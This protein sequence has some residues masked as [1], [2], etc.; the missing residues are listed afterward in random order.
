MNNEIAIFCNSFTGAIG[1]DR[2]V[3][4]QAKKLSLISGNHVTIITF[5]K[6]RLPPDGVDIIVIKS[7]C[8]FVIER[9]WRLFFPFN[10]ITISYLLKRIKNIDTIYSHQYPLNWLAYLGKEFYGIKY[11]Y[12]HHHLN[13]PESYI[14][15]IQQIYAKLLNILTLWTAKKSNCAISIS[16]YSRKSLLKEIGLDSIV[17]YNEIDKDRFH[18]GIDGTIIR[19]RYNIDNEPIIL[20]VGGITP[21]KGIHLLINV[22]QIVKNRFPNAKLII[23]GKK[24]FDKYY[25]KLMQMNDV[26]II[27]TG[28]I[29]DDELPLYYASCNVYATASLWE[30]FN[31]P[32][33]EAK[34]CGKPIV[35]FD[36]G[37]HRELIDSPETGL[38][39]P[40]S[41]IVVM[42]EA[43]IEILSFQKL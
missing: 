10:I 33:V 9:L 28:Y 32:L 14:G 38:L 29:S 23:V 4:S 26:S 34:S 15:Q 5:K 13:P 20:Y 16:Q 39:V 42:A 19:N 36:I 7:P 12:Y 21:P 11:I 18:P 6:E 40:E 22:F 1:V 43:I 31:I 24:S 8:G 3:Y 2:V 30:G 37:P 41:N 27:F 17:I 35:A 25:Q